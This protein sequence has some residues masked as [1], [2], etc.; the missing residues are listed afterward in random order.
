MRGLAILI[1]AGVLLAA[2]GGPIRVV[3]FAMLV[4]A[5]VVSVRGDEGTSPVSWA[6]VFSFAASNAAHYL[7][8]GFEQP[9]AYTICE[10]VVVSMA[11]F[12]HVYSGSRLMIATVAVAMVSIGSNFYASSIGA[13]TP[14]Q[15]NI[16]EGA[17]NLCFAAECLLVAAVGISERLASRRGLSDG[18][19]LPA[20]HGRTAH[21]AET[22]R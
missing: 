2:F 21:Q 15:Q 18:R 1:G 11:F 10:A 16:W 12:A 9:Q 19:I 7:L 6:L 14:R 8:G 5:A 4:A 13:L 22:R 3:G 20:L 17:T